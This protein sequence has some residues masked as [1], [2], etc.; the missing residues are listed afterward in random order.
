MHSSCK[1][2]AMQMPH[3]Q[4]QLLL[5]LSSN[6]CSNCLCSGLNTCNAIAL[7]HAETLQLTLETLETLETGGGG[8][9]LT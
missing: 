6:K 8:G 5:F 7:A 9:Q 2:A 1:Q 4:L 3:L